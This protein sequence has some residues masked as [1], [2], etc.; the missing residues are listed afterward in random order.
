MK[1]VSYKDR[2][3][4]ANDLKQVYKAPTKEAGEQELEELAKKWESKYPNVI[5]SWWDNREE[6]STMFKYPEEIRKLYTLPIQ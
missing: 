1:F 5:K 3:E 6:L 4:L 2:K